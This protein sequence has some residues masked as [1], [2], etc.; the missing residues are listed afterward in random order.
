MF[1]PYRIEAEDR[2]YFEYGHGTHMLPTQ[3][4][5]KDFPE[6]ER[7]Y[8]SNLAGHDTTL[9]VVIVET[10]SMM[11]VLTHTPEEVIAYMTPLIP[12][13]LSITPNSLCYVRLMNDWLGVGMTLVDE[14]GGL[15]NC[16]YLTPFYA[17]VYKDP[18]A[19]HHPLALA[20]H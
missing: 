6:L 9:Y 5:P 8:H 11:S 15:N 19:M 7:Y 12:T 10:Q 3:Q 13:G 20:I 4:L 18:A 16:I 1:K 2:E 14:E 17:T